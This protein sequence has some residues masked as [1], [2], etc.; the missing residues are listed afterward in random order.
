ML[1]LIQQAN[2]LALREASSSSLNFKYF[3]KAVSLLL[4]FKFKTKVDCYISKLIKVSLKH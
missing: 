3:C 2:H 1:K 4:V